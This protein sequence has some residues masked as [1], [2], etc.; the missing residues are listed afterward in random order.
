MFYAIKTKIYCILTLFKPK[1][2]SGK[3][4]HFN[5]VSI[6]LFRFYAW[7]TVCDRLKF[8]VFV[9]YHSYGNRE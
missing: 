6:W 3:T 2:F 8:S 7:K 9:S 4:V 1:A 5:V